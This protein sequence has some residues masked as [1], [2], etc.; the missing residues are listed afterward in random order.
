M[1]TY[2]ILDVLNYAG[3][4]SDI[5]NF[6]ILIFLKFCTRSAFQGKVT[7]CS[8]CYFQAF[9]CAGYTRNQIL[10]LRRFYG[11]NIPCGISDGSS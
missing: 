2:V 10:K 1:K 4:V 9:I 7:P 8:Q 6:F 11:P 5:Q 3:S